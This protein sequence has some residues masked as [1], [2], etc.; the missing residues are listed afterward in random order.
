MTLELNKVTSQVAQLGEQAAQRKRE[1]DALAPEVRELLRAHR[2]DAQLVALAQRATL[3]LEA[4]DRSQLQ[5]ALTDLEASASKLPQ[6][7]IVRYTLGRAYFTK[8]DVDQARI[9]FKA[10]VEMQPDYLA[11]RV[12]L[13]ELHLLKG[14]N[15]LALQLAD[16]S[17]L[18]GPGNPQIRLLRARA[19]QATGKLDDALAAYDASPNHAM[20]HILLSDASLWTI[21]PDWPYRGWVTIY[22]P[23]GG[24]CS[25][26]SD[27][28]KWAVFQLGN[29]TVDNVA[30]ANRYF[31]TQWGG[32]PYN[33]ANGA[34]YGYS[35]CGPTSGV[36]A[37]SSNGSCTAIGHASP[38]T[39]PTTRRSPP[40]STSAGA[41][42]P[43]RRAARSAAQPFAVPP[44]SR[45]TPGGS[46]THR[47]SRSTRIDCQS[48]T[49][50]ALA[51]GRSVGTTVGA[52]AASRWMPGV[53]A[54]SSKL[55]S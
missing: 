14:E 49:V 41:T 45:R 3:W 8:G 2:D 37:L 9:Q 16:E 19:L 21:P 5:K 55:R 18:Y 48:G 35:D 7:P 39:V 20:G 28:A 38:F 17:L 50:E 27:M 32:T 43:S 15:A 29:G 42:R 23:A 46:R 10:A 47:P 13:I 25:N 31:V 53:A 44:R 22:A 51:G 12:S 34:P 6:N 30:D 4:G 26:L 40:A 24:L 11:P 33:S 52:T 36:M 54:T 1:L